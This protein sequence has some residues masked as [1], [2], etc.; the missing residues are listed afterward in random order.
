MGEKKNQKC[1]QIYLAG[2]KMNADGGLIEELYG[3][4]VY[5]DFWWSFGV[6]MEERNFFKKIFFFNLDIGVL[7]GIVQ[8]G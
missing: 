1:A 3:C 2:A 6:K 5:P 7:C 8:A 4:V